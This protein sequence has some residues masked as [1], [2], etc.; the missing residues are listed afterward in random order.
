M[1]RQEEVLGCKDLS[2]SASWDGLWDGHQLL[3]AAAEAVV[4]RV[5]SSKLGLVYVYKG[6]GTRDLHHSSLRLFLRLLEVL[7]SQMT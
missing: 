3:C 4:S 6:C 2:C 5:T 1:P 7:L